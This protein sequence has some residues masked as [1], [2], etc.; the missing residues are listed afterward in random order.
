MNTIATPSMIE[1]TQLSAGGYAGTGRRLANRTPRL[2]RI[3]LFVL[4]L[5]LAGCAGLG[6][7]SGGS[8]ALGAASPS[9]TASAAASTA[10]APAVRAG[11][12]NPPRSILYV[13][14]SFM[15]YNNSLH[16][17]TS[18]LARGSAQSAAAQHRATSLT[19]SGSGIDWHD[20]ESYLRPDGLGRYS[21]V[22]DNEVR[23]NPPGRQ[24]D[25]VLLMDCSQCPVHPT[26]SKVFFEYSK[27][28]SATARA[29]GVEPMFL[30]TWAY[31]D[32]PEM[33]QGLA[34]AYTEAGRQNNAHVIPAG[35]AF[36]A[37]IAKRPD[38]NLYVPDKR[39]PSLAGSYLTAATMVASIWNVNPVGSTFTAGLPA[40][41]ARHLQ[42][43][44]WET[45]RRFHGR[46]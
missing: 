38:I 16:G 22:G 43:V 6:G 33:T 12:A 11:T 34:D 3:G 42:E 28:H 24:Y 30:M 17:L 45:T 31:A 40:D 39:H 14:N 13:G 29:K 8:G 21:F 7:G 18:Q 23:F 35:L 37:S 2:Q 27:K 46:P 4:A 25:S 36:A 19:I 10:T 1:A 32:K 26:L 44:A 20:L 9:A 5:S 15:Y 41:V